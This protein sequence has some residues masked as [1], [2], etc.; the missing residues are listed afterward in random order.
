MVD[1]YVEGRKLDVFEGLDFSFNYS[2]ADIREPDKR[3]TEYTKTIKC[4]ATQNNDELFGHIYEFNISNSYSG[5][6]ANIEANFNPKKKASAT[7]TKD[8][9]RVMKGSM[10]LRRVVKKQSEYTY[11]VVFV[12]Q[13]VNIFSVLGD[14]YIGAND[15]NG[16]PYIDWSDLDH[17]LNRSNQIASWSAPI[18]EGY[19]Y[20]LIDW[21]KRLIYAPGGWRRYWV[22]DLRPALYAKEIVDRIF[23][24]AGFTYTSDFFDS[25]FFKRLIIPLSQD[26][27]LSAQQ[28]YDRSFK[29]VKTEYQRMHRLESQS[30][31]SL[32]NED[33]MTNW[34]HVSKICFEDDSILG[35]DNPS[36]YVQ[37]SIAGTL[38]GAP[39]NYQMQWFGVHRVDTF[40][41][42]LDLRV[43]KNGDFFR[44]VYTGK[45]RIIK[46]INATQST[47]VIGESAFRFTGI[48]GVI[49]TTITQTIYVEAQ[50][51]MYN[52][53]AVWVDIYA[54]DD[55]EDGY[56]PTFRDEISQ[57]PL[58]YRLE[59]YCI[60]G[61]FLN[62]PNV[63]EIHEGDLTNIKAALPDVSMSD[64]IM[65]IFK[66]FNLYVTP[67]RDKDNDLIIE[68]RDDF[69]NG[70][71][72]RDWT[73]KLDHSQD[74]IIQPLALLTANEY[75]YTY[76]EDGDYYND[77]YQNTHGHTHG[78]RLITADNDFLQNKH[79]TEI[80]FSP[81]PL[82]N[83]GDSSRI[84]PKVYDSDIDEGVAQTDANIRILYYGGL[85]Y[86]NPQWIFESLEYGVL[87]EYPL[88]YP[89]A[90]HLTHPIT[91]AQDIH[92]GLPFEIFY[93]ENQY[94]GPISITSNNLF[95]TFHRKQIEEITDK[96]SKI[97]SAK[98]YLDPVDILKLDF[99]DQIIIDNSIWRLNKVENFN[100]FKEGTTKVELIKVAKKADLPV[101]KSLINSGGEL[102]GE[103]KPKKPKK[104]R[105]E[106]DYPD[107]QGVVMG[108]RNTVHPEANNFNVNGD[109]NVIERGANNIN[110]QGN[111]NTVRSGVSDVTLI[112][113]NNVI[114]TRSGV[115]YMNNSERGN[116]ELVEGGEDEV[117]GLFSDVP[118]FTID[119]GEDEVNE[120]YSESAIY[121]LEGGQHGTTGQ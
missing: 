53:D 97:L 43:V 119:G 25:D 104:K 7:V 82:T 98:F 54:P 112:N 32:G 46:F 107:V 63:D 51:E 96:D 114:V 109:D 57:S 111:N 2:I 69:Y 59:F 19:V 83:D 75:E 60:G 13:L 88:Q 101:V 103:K 29:A 100:P 4:P 14:K 31:H 52:G 81:S 87:S 15:A 108:R 12:G 28:A 48:D 21:G 1:I 38:A 55:N 6:L 77:R 90:G 94:T 102:Q 117:R 45:V 73:Y 56:T 17:Y 120:Q 35:F 20:P 93:T 66:M 74:V 34:G 89:Y 79:T 62:E 116:T 85:L 16:L 42:S 18:G 105:N 91:P 9:I 47:E 70:G 36:E 65:S 23:D 86:S 121:L 8:G 50:T 11:E 44:E 76:S 40:K 67:N 5:A 78:R 64:F 41:T 26:M 61:Y 115:T 33:Y 80:I 118:I 84:I 72:T 71:S 68:T 92:F 49:G 106:N 30:P 27:G 37:N 22:D 3:S 58:R 113:T 24:F 110:I 10:Q 99:R 39:D 95:N